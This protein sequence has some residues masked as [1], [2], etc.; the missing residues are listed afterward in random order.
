MYVG[1]SSVGEIY[2]QTR[3]TGKTVAKKTLAQ[4]LGGIVI[5]LS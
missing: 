5:G 3:T 4:A 1:S 2:I